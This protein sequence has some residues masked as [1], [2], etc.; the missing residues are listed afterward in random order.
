M[1]H[2]LAKVISIHAL[3]NDRDLVERGASL[4]VHGFG[5][6]VGISV[7]HAA[8]CSTMATAR[9]ARSSVIAAKKRREAM[10]S[11]AEELHAA[12]TELIAADDAAMNTG[13][14]ICSIRILLD[15]IKE[16]KQ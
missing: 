11:L 5:S 15:R 8:T 16:P 6:S 14:S 7:H 10:R 1:T 13:P 4:L 12:C 3:A 2:Q 9:I